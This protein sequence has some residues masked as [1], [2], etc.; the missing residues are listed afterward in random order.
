VTPSTE[1]YGIVAGTG[2]GAVRIRGGAIDRVAD[3]AGWL[4]GDLGSG[5]WLGHEAAKAVVADLDGRAEPTALTRPVLE[6]LGIA[7]SS[8]RAQDSRPVPLRLMTDAVYALRPIEL[9]R[10]APIVIAHRDDPVA[11]RLIAQ[12]ERYLVDD[13]LT[14]FDPSVWGPIALGGG[15]IPHLTG[16]PA[17]IG[18]IART[19]HRAA[20]IRRVTDGSV[21]AIV[22]ALRAMGESVDETKF[23]RIVTSLAS[24]HSRPVLP[25]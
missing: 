17:T 7:W 8:E 12:A 3:A 23:Q 21:G 25:I 10:L 13:F 1:G 22:L 5:Y 19:P 4:L 11:A 20:D 15:V 9:A 16:L 14:V 24:R 18:D 6:N 2:S